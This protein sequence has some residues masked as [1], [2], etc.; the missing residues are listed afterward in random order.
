[1]DDLPGQ[2]REM[3]WNLAALA[4]ELRGRPLG[5]DPNEKALALALA[6][7]RELRVYV[8]RDEDSPAI[9]EAVSANFTG[10]TRFDLVSARL[11]RPELLVEAEGILCWDE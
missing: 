8:P 1:V 10:L 3:F 5:T 7:Y 2:I 11:C 4:G 9:G 6:T